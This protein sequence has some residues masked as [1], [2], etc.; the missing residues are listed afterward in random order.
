MAFV[1]PALGA[2]MTIDLAWFTAPANGRA[3]ANAYQTFINAFRVACR[4][5]GNFVVACSNNKQ[6]FFV[7]PNCALTRHCTA[8]GVWSPVI[9]YN[10]VAI[11]NITLATLNT[12]LGHAHPNVMDAH[13]STIIWFTSEAARSEIISNKFFKM[14][15]APAGHQ[16][17]PSALRSPAYFQNCLSLVCLGYTLLV[18]NYGATCALVPGNH[19]PLVQ[20]NYQTFID[21]MTFGAGVVGVAL[22]AARGVQSGALAQLITDSSVHL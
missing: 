10:H 16:N 5:G 6:Y 1:A 11:I 14:I 22:A 12:A 3:N 8:G 15:D 4:A 7:G 17:N 19:F 13:L 20:A 2:N 21:Q 18:N 9:P